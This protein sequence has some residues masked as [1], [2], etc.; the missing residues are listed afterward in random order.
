ME[1]WQYFARRRD[2]Q[3]IVATTNW[4][5]RHYQVQALAIA[6]A[7]SVVIC[8]SWTN[9]GV[10]QSNVNQH[11]VMP[12]ITEEAQAN[13]AQTIVDNN[14]GKLPIVLIVEILIAGLLSVGFFSIYLTNKAKRR[15]LVPA[16]VIGESTPKKPVKSAEIA[17]ARLTRQFVEKPE[18]NLEI[19][20]VTIAKGEILKAIALRLRQCLYLE[21][22]LRTSV[23]EVRRVIKSDRVLIYSLNPAN[24]EGTVVAESVDSEYPQTVNLKID[25]PCF[26]TYHVEMYK[27]GRI[28]T[29][30][31]IHQDKALNDCHIR[32]LEQFGV[33]ANLIAPILRNDQL[34]GLLIAHQCTAPR[35]WQ[36]EE[37]D[38]FAGLA[39]QIGLTI[40][41]VNF[42][43]SQ[44]Q[45]VER[46]K[47]L[48]EITLKLRDTLIIEELLTIAVK[49]IRR[50]IK[51]DR[52]IIYSLDPDYHA[53]TVVGES[54]G[55]GWS[56][57]LKLTIDDPCLDQVR[58]NS[59]KYGYVRVVN[60][61][62]QEPTLNQCH[63]KL[64]EQF[65]VK[66]KLV[67]PILNNNHLFGLLIA[68][69]C[70]QPRHW[71][72]SEIDLFAQLASQVGF[73]VSQLS[74]FET[75]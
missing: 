56:P 62:Y 41:Q 26:R 74:L 19:E 71:E 25:D 31:D 18:P 37:I 17:V 52:V 28:R 49:E 4:Q 10:S 60:N 46:A 73:A 61:I 9:V 23:I 38:L 48:R 63:I 24:W 59:Y 32:M 67:A 3:Q 6:V 39:I 14:A 65:G 53:K 35:V 57:T 47:L 12:K 34:L 55:S 42:I 40:D 7:I 69:Q 15:L 27:Q 13:E 50:V 72:K 58:T 8:P 21:D 33:K 66:A 30:N 68:H 64:L 20:S 44:E 45:A 16:T 54:V 29:I 36:P 75:M 5:H 11:L 22:L 70:Y 43:E 1:S 51:S 2:R